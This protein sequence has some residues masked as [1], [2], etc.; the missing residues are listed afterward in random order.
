MR[1]TRH[2]PGLARR[3]ELYR[4]FGHG[5]GDAKEMIELPPHSVHDRSGGGVLASRHERLATVLAPAPS[6]SAP[7]Q[8]ESKGPG[9]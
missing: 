7:S 5:V 2:T 1:A 3:T 6:R 8:R 9:A 4:D